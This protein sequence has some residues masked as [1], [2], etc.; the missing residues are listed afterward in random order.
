MLNAHELERV[1][2]MIIRENK[3]NMVDI[4]ET[5]QKKYRIMQHYVEENQLASKEDRASL[6]KIGRVINEVATIEEKTGI[7]LIHQ[8][9]FADE[10]NYPNEVWKDDITRRDEEVLFP[11]SDGI[12]GRWDK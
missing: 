8:I 7:D 2:K 3:K 5:L 4:K 1:I 12:N 11:T 6:E 10:I 9:L